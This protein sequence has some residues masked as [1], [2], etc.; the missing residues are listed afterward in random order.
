MINRQALLSDI[1]GLLKLIEAD[2]LDRSTSL[3]VPEIGQALRTRY[4]EAQSASR[5]A[6]NFEDWRS[7]TITQAAA[8]WVLSAV[9]VRFLEDNGLIPVPKISGPA[10]E[11]LKRARDEH[12]L[13]FR[14]HPKLNDRD[15]LLSL[16]DSLTKHAAT[17]EVFGPHNPLRELPQWLSGDA[18]TALIGFF[19]K[20]DA[21]TGTLI[22]DFTDPELDTRFLGDLYQD[23]SEAARKKYALL[24]T[25]V[26]VEEFILDRTLSPALDEFGLAQPG[27]EARLE[28]N[29]RLNPADRFRMIDPACGSGHFLLGAFERLVQAWCSKE[30]GTNA[31][32][33]VQ[34]ALDSI[35]GVDLNPYAIAIARF[36]LI[37]RALQ[38]LSIKRLADAP[39]F[40]VELACGDSLL[41]GAHSGDQ[42]TMGFSSIDHVYQAEDRDL[43]EKL[44]KP[45]R[46]HAVVA[47]PPYITPKDKN[48]N[49]LYRDRFSTCH[50][51]YSLAV[52]FMQR[53][54]NLATAG[55]YTGQITANSFMKREFGSKLI[56]QFFPRVDLTHVIDTSGAYIP[57]HGTPTVILFGRNRKPVG[58]TVRAVLGI[59]GEPSTP[60]DPAQGLVW[61]SILRQIDKAGAQ[62]DYTSTADVSRE[63]LGRHPWSIGGGGAAELKEQL[64]EACESSL[65]SSVDSIGFMCITKQDDVFSQPRSVL[66][67]NA[68]EGEHIR[69][70][71]I[72]EEVRDW[73]TENGDWVIY[74]YDKA[75]RTLS[76]DRVPKLLRFMWL[77]KT[78]LEDR[79]VFGGQTYRQ[80]GKP[81]YEYGQIPVDRQSTPLSITFAFVASHN[82]FVLDRGGKVFKQSAPIIKLPA[83]ATEDDH[84]A[85][86]GVLNSSTACFW[87]KQVLSDKGNGGIGGGISDEKWEHR[88]E[89]DGT[90]LKQVPLPESR[91]T[92]LA[93]KLD[94]LADAMQ[95]HAPAQ[96]VARW[97]GE[98]DFA[99]R[100]GLKDYLE[101]SLIQWNTLR[102]LMIAQQEELDWQCYRL[103]GL[104]DEDLTYGEQPP[105]IAFGERAFEMIMGRQIAVDEL[106]TTWFERHNALAISA[107]L[108]EWPADY[109][110]LVLRRIEAIKT[111]P[112]ITLIEKPEYK[113]RWN[114]EAWEDQQQRALQN[115]L[116]DRLESYFDFDGRMNEL[117]TP[118][119]QLSTGLTS[120]ARLADIARTD[121][122]FCAVGAVYR[123]DVAFDV[124]R[125]VSDLVTAES[126]PLLPVLRYKPPGLRKRAEWEQTW[127]LQRKEDA[128]DAQ[129]L[130]DADAEALKK[131][132][133][134]NIPVPPKYTNT[135]FLKSDYWRLRGKLD[136]PKERWVSFP[137][138]AANDGT[139]L[140]AWAGYN[141]LQLAQAISSY[142]VEVQEN[143]GG[144]EDPRLAPLLACMIE[145]LPWLKQWHNA[146]DPAFGVAMSDY[147]EG[148]VQ[149]EARNL[150]QTQAEI[151]DWQPPAKATKAKKKS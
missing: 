134:G 99:A 8:A 64:E 38:L 5:T 84:L 41:H 19:Q 69:P 89:H 85:L 75:V 51:Q 20:I 67:R 124:S 56:E 126:V 150:G 139:L 16:F 82:H 22:H 9:F 13:F 32:V 68:C 94:F 115:W 43:L 91:P 137:H 59:K 34:R 97:A 123:D 127:A 6:L 98:P 93:S 87:M 96:V 136:V 28:D 36:R 25:P 149:E 46:Y 4:A 57:G 100:V 48:L 86:L 90:K 95:D 7:D 132:Q 26:F 114:T 142:Y 78:V 71:G 30:P 65:E 116:L 42:A 109:Q 44:L 144:G 138:C 106:Q 101:T 125:L 119:A 103:Y 24:Q 61:T 60:A 12:E 1:Q 133:V 50:R 105:P 77:N 145:L 112:N 15:Y 92:T 135:D 128:I 80:V 45:G 58:N 17:S 18:G 63:T 113:R 81:W 14:S 76:K 21:N 148:F 23:L 27:Y 31:S 66:V 39:A 73:T 35:H 102:Q 10:G 129:G 130:P 70:F 37:V 62:D 79:K 72:G 54:F 122:E 131:Q 52:P 40:H 140:I 143:L 108:P 118:T 83:D 88:F 110:A 107:P 121:A 146:V 147:F 47:N 104:T 117:G 151:R 49:Q 120:V 53:I 74:P 11:K 141:H 33:L 111:N 3:E 55:G 29:G 2:L